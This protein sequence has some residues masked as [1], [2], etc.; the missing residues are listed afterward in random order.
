MMRDSSPQRNDQI[1]EL[2]EFIGNA[3]TRRVLVELSERGSVP[4]QLT[5]DD[6]DGPAYRRSDCLRDLIRLGLGRKDDQGIVELTDRV[7]V[8]RSNTF[9]QIVLTAADGS[10]VDVT[11]PVIVE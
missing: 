3:V 5:A 2:L 11:Y 1:A 4:E 9:I 8:I 10:S 6:V 7:R